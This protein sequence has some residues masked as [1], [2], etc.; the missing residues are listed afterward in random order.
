MGRMEAPCQSVRSDSTKNLRLAISITSVRRK[1]NE[2]R[3]VTFTQT[4][5]KE[6]NGSDTMLLFL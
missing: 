5:V 4:R 6:I 1:K 3:S 2:E